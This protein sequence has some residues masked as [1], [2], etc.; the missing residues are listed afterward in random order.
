MLSTRTITEKEYPMANEISTGDPEEQEVEYINMAS[1]WI[2]TII[3]WGIWAFIAG[4]NIYLIV[5][6]CKG[7]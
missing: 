3:G 6:L 4:L 1:G 2:V 5:M 7:K